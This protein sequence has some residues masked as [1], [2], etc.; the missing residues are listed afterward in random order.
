MKHVRLTM[1]ANGRE[2]EIHPTY[3]L[4][5]NGACVERSA[6]LQWNW[7]G[8]TLGVLH[9][10]V[11]EMSAFAA[12]LDDIDHIID[13]E[14]EPAGS[15]AFYAYLYDEMTPASRKLYE[16]ATYGGIV[17]VPPIQY[18]ENGDVVASVFGPPER[19]QAGV[20]EVPPPVEVSI[21][22][23]GGLTGLAQ[24]S[25]SYLSDRQQEALSVGL[26]LGYYEMPREASQ[27]DVAEELGCAPSTAAEHLQKAETK[28]VRSAL[29]T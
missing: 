29:E 25:E 19:I 1:T 27:E 2:A 4:L 23:I 13:Y 28:V 26:E 9:Y 5:A 3:D 10:T 17:V 8:D 22:S 14:L 18:R 11:G 16:P 21:D 12:A 6:E 24:A 20:E 7:T 15:D